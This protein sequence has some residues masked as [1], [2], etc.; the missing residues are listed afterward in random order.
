V[1]NDTIYFYGIYCQF[2][3]YNNQLVVSVGV[4]KNAAPETP[5]A[6]IMHLDITSTRVSQGHEVKLRWQAPLK[7]RA[8]I[9]KSPQ[10]VPF[11]P[12]ET[13][14]RGLV[15]KQGTLLE[16][17]PDTLTDKWSQPG[18]AYYTPIVL[19]QEMAYIGTSLQHVCVDDVSDLKYQNLGSTLRLQWTWP[20]NC[21]EVLVSFDTEGWPNPQGARTNTQKVTRAEYEYMGHYDIRGTTNQDHYIVVSAIIKQGSDQIVSPGLRVQARLA[22]QI[23]V[24]Y[25]IKMS[26]NLFRPKQLMLHL[27]TRTPGTLPT[28]LIMSKQGRLPINKAEGNLFHRQEGPINI[29]KDLVIILPDKAVPPKTF[30]KLYLEDDSLYNLVRINHPSE[31]KLRLV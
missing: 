1:L 21:Q 18:I 2:K 5:P 20:A 14:P 6:P 10:R 22:S 24:E 12:G 15:D 17:R 25:E 31:D 11:K 7:G 23:V 13:V 9:L 16:E 8:L 27:H 3:D 29:E 26:R 4:I 19:F 28:F 30:G